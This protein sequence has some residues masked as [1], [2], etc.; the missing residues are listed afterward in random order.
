MALPR[1]EDIF[2]SQYLSPDDLKP[3]EVKTV[4]ISAMDSHDEWYINNRRQM[5][6]GKPEV[7]VI[8]EIAGAKKKIVLN[9]TSAKAL[10]K[11]FGEYNADNGAGWV[12]KQVRVS[13]GMIS[14]K[15]CVLV[16][17]VEMV[18]TE[19]EGATQDNA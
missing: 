10:K 2:G 14:K 7:K 13:R 17:P 15:H 6:D 16:H 3:G 9:K 5:K 1:Y 4:T 18:A 11:A 12:G 8:L 19:A